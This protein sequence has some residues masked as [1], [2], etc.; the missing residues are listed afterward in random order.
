[1]TVP[2]PRLLLHRIRGGWRCV[3]GL[4]SLRGH[5]DCGDGENIAPYDPLV[6]RPQRGAWRVCTWCG[7]HWEAAYDPMYGCPFWQRRL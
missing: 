2:R 5:I 4:H 3:V 7:A 1:M 6:R